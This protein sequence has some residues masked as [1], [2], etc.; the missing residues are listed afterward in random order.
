MSSTKAKAQAQV[1]TKEITPTPLQ[2][3][4]PVQP[5]SKTIDSGVGQKKSTPAKFVLSP[6]R[7]RKLE[8]AKQ[9]AIDDFFIED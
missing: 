2:F 4:R 9:Q 8:R 1:K 7:A 6:S 3:A 5:I